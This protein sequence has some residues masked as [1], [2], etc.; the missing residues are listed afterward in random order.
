MTNHINISPSVL[1]TSYL[2]HEFMRIC[3]LRK[4]PKLA[5]M[6]HQTSGVAVTLTISRFFSCFVGFCVGNGSLSILGR[7]SL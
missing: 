4:S 5:R 6:S 2:S 7:N 3:L 1:S